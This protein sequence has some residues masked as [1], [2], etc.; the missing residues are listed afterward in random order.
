MNGKSKFSISLLLWINDPD[1]YAPCIS[2][3]DAQNGLTIHGPKCTRLEGGVLGH[4]FDLIRTE[5][6]SFNPITSWISL[7]LTYDGTSLLYYINGILVSTHDISLYTF[8]TTDLP[9]KLSRFW[10]DYYK[11]KIQDVRIYNRALTPEEVLIN[12]NLT[13]AD[14]TA[15]IQAE[16]GTTYVSQINE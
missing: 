11:G 15:M 9:V 12:Y 7:N 3:G 8:P 16:N 1:E 14:K 13:K 4:R 5:Y 2:I 10:G 6:L